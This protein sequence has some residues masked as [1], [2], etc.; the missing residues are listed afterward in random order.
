MGIEPKE[1]QGNPEALG[2][3]KSPGRVREEEKMK[4]QISRELSDEVLARLPE[5]VES[6]GL[7]DDERESVI[8]LGRENLL[9]RVVEAKDEQER[10]VKIARGRA[11]TARQAE[12]KQLVIQSKCKHRTLTPT[13]P[14]TLL[15]GQTMRG[16]IVLICQAC[17]KKFSIPEQTGMP[18]PTVELVP[19]HDHIGGARKILEGLDFGNEPEPDLSD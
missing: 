9:R 1:D 4:A 2:S 7:A 18:T 19:P 13:G 12:H 17:R 6:L 8:R 15:S 3:G 11:L 16:H 14:K 5:L 10:L